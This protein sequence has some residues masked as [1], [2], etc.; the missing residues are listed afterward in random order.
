M[1]RITFA[2][3]A[4]LG[5]SLVLGSPVLRAQ[6]GPLTTDPP[7][8]MT[9]DQLIQKFTTKEKEFKTARQQCTY[10]QSVKLQTLQGTEVTS[11]YRQVADVRLDPNGNKVKTI[12]LSPQASMTLSPEDEADVESRL[13]FT[14]STDEAPEYK[15]TYK[16]QQQED[17]LHCY[18]FDVEPRQLEPH[19]RYFQGRIWVD[20]HDFQIVRMAGKSVP[21]IL[22]KKRKQQPNLFPKFT[23]YRELIDGKYWVP[24]YSLT[25]D[26][27]HFPTADVHLVGTVMASD[28]RCPGWQAGADKP[29]AATPASK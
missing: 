18:V 17:D 20:D 10:R 16:G 8:G 25:D 9:A 6:E 22:P 4:V 29:K 19:K 5:I 27:L 24:T 13:H 23:T 2:Y 26:T 12:V 28:I 7:K 3:S 1:L 21:D 11:E 15:I 14:L